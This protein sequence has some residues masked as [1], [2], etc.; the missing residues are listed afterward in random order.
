MGGPM[1]GGMPG[2][3]KDMG[4]IGG[5]IGGPMGGPIGGP[6]GP[7]MSGV[8]PLC[9]GQGSPS[10]VARAGTLFADLMV[11]GYPAMDPGPPPIMGPGGIMPG[12]NE[13]V[14]GKRG[15]VAGCGE[16]GEG[17]PPPPSLAPHGLN[18][19]GGHF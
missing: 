18:S 11:P 8:C 16:V 3:G 2:P 14:G 6:M 9:T 15:L 4:P 7:P 13:V 10:H 1:G 5:P 19:P 12:C 17:F